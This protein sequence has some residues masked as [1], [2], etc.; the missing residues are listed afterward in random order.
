M[1][2]WLHIVDDVRTVLQQAIQVKRYLIEDTPQGPRV[3]SSARKRPAPEG[4]RVAG[5][6]S[7]VSVSTEEPVVVSLD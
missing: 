6:W 5:Q 7:L 2:Y 1:S 4:E 3:V